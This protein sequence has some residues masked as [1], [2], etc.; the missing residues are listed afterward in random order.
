MF[1]L[2]VCALAC[3]AFLA[4][5]VQ[6]DLLR[7]LDQAILRSLRDGGDFASP[8]GPQGLASYMR[9][10]TALGSFAVLS[11]AVLAVAVFLMLRGVRGTAATVLGFAIGGTLL[12]EAA[13]HLF[14]RGRPDAVP[15]LVDVVTLSFP[16]AHAMQSTVVWSTFA[17]LMAEAQDD[18]RV[19]IYLL[20]LAALIAFAVGFSRLYLGVHW[21][22]DVVAG[23]ALGVAWV[24]GCWL[25]RQRLVRPAGQ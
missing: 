9:D 21:P 25:L 20:C 5:A 24:S 13:K 4:F 22:T 16:S 11:F 1:W 18:R 3:F 8:I 12:G 7:H 6:Q 19:R 23:W 15:H 2:F 10:V 14:A 17:I